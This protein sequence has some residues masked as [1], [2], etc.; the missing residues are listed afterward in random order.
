[1]IEHGLV[2]P[3]E[4]LKY[5]D[6][7][8]DRIQAY[9]FLQQLSW[10]DFYQKKYFENP[11]TIWENLDEYKTGFSHDD[12][13]DDLPSDIL[14]ATTNVAVINTLIKTLQNTGYLHNHARLYLAAYI[15]HWRRIKWQVGARWM[16]SHLIDGN[17][18]SNNYSWQWVAST[19]SQKAYIFNLD[20][21]R[22]Y[23][24][25][26]GM[27]LSVEHNFPIYGSYEVIAQ[28]L[29]PKKAA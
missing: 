16:L 28:R 11:E 2:E 26:E 25:N 22:K 21:V 19:G 17:L 8:Q 29:F 13:A 18:A 7:Q 4:I 12:Y 27:N 24:A 20:N 3:S 5:I 10:R 9:D 6:S 1:Y 15:V 23:A 14:S